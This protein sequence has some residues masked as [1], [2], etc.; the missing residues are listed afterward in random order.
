M[1]FLNEVLIIYSYELILP[2]D[3]ALKINCIRREINL[4][5]PIRKKTKHG[6]GFRHSTRNLLVIMQSV[7]ALSYM[8][9]TA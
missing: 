4:H 2:I 1:F 7:L 5:F 3:L 9:N 8:R 6:I